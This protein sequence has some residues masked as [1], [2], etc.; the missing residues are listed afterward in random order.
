M[1]SFSFL[2]KSNIFNTLKRLPITYL[3]NIIGTFPKRLQVIAA[4]IVLLLLQSSFIPS[5]PKQ[6]RSKLA[7]KNSQLRSRGASPNFTSGDPLS[8]NIVKQYLTCRGDAN[9]S[10]S[11]T[12]SGGIS[13][14]RYS[15]DLGQTWQSSGVF[16]NLRAG[17]Y[18]LTL[19][20]ASANQL[21]SFVT[22]G[23]YEAEWTGAFSTDWHTPANW[24]TGNVP[25]ANTH[26]IIPGGRPECIIRYGNATAASIQ[27]RFG[28]SLKVM[29][30]KNLLISG[31]CPFL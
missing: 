18:T 7:V 22:I 15:I 20:D 14:Y 9:G 12:G 1:K 27:E 4:F 29:D 17:I 16:N 5:E 13:P 23:V 2:K 10:F 24:N 26:V 31:K 11:A 8:I 30:F 6:L 3:Y 28:A 21:D 19:E 25:N